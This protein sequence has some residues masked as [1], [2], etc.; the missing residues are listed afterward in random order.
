MTVSLI[1][2]NTSN[3]KS[4]VFLLQRCR[5][6]QHR[7]NPQCLF[8]RGISNNIPDE[9]QKSRYTQRPQSWHNRYNCGGRNSLPHFSILSCQYGAPVRVTSWLVTSQKRQFSW[10][11]PFSKSGIRDNNAVI[12]SARTK[13]ESE[14]EEPRKIQER[15]DLTLLML[16]LEFHKIAAREDQRKK[17]EMETEEKEQSFS[18]STENH[19]LQNREKMID[20]A[21]DRLEEI[22]IDNKSMMQ[23][24]YAL[25]EALEEQVV[26]LFGIFSSIDEEL[27][28]LLPDGV[29]ATNNNQIDID[30]YLEE[31]LRLEL[32]RTIDELANTK[33]SRA[34]KGADPSDFLTLKRGAIET[35]LD[36]RGKEN[37]LQE[38]DHKMDRSDH[39]SVAPKNGEESNDKGQN[40]LSWAEADEFGYH[41]SIDRER[42]RLIRYYQSINLCRSGKMRDKIGYS[43]VAFRSSI[44][45][46]G[47]G[48]YVDGYARAGSILAF[49]PGPVWAKEH[50]V[51][52]SIDEERDLE[53]NDSY[54]MSLRA[55]DYMIDSRRSPYTVLTDDNCNLMALGHIV[56]HPTP[57][58]PP[59]CRSAMLNFTK[60]MDIG[61]SV[62]LKRYIP[63]TYARSRNVTL[64]DSLWDRDVIEMHSL[65]LVAT[66]DI[67]NEEIFYDYRLASSHLPQWYHQ[68]NDT[69]YE[70]AHNDD[71][72]EENS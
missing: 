8:G 51:N 25:Q 56:N 53:R 16:A 72:T 3:F 31:M 24:R 47:R 37:F 60:G 41:E 19:Y 49:Q 18:L 23:L 46:A 15:K 42:N 45:G 61:S 35:L 13:T 5:C 4:L 21:F 34:P 32:E 12:G 43:V 54:Q 68:V 22:E 28:V 69:A 66:R 67:C 57:S 26:D 9:A 14:G 7:Q 38:E 70:V 27:L 44:P 33:R 65:V 59:S 10:W 29:D 2:S 20:S 39:S 11:N 6:L 71:D 62:K 50:L 64:M 48:V 55:D 1:Q 36:R 40:R 63:N 52:L 30:S 17:E 58:K